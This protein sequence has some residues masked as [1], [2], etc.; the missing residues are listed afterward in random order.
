MTKCKPYKDYRGFCRFKSLEDR[1]MSWPSM[2]NY[3]L[4]GKYLLRPLRENEIDEVV[5]IYRVGYPE[6]YGNTYYEVVLWPET[7]RE[8]LESENGF[9]HG[10]WFLN[11]IE[12]TDEKKLIG[13]MKFKMD[14]G[15]MSI[16]WQSGVIHPDYRGI[17][18][19][20][21]IF[22]KYSDEFSEK[23]GAKYGHTLAATIHK[24]TQIVLKDLG[25]KIRGVFPGYELVWNHENKYYRHSFVFFDKFY[26]NGEILVPK[27]ME[28][29]PETEK[30][31]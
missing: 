5:E 13:A 28:L 29:I 23:T 10:E 2:K 21:R 6:L 17:K 18:G 12:K 11:V 9:M 16:N 22:C 26:N 19:L 1:K 14:R 8:L 24:K 25:W 20:F 3:V 31:L 27:E 15:N 7:I 30:I 4:N